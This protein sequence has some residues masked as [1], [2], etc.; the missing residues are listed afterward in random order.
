MQLPKLLIVYPNQFGYH[1]DTYMYCKYLQYKY[2]ITYVCFDQGFEK[3][4]IPGTEVVYVPYGLGKIKRLFLFFKTAIQKSNELNK[5]I[6][7][8]VQFK[9]SALL[10]LFLTS[11]LSILDYRTG[12]LSTNSL[13]RKFYNLWMRTDAVFFQRTSVISA[14]LRKMLLL[15]RST[16]V[17]PLGAEELSNQTK[18]FDK[19][20]L[21]Y[22]GAIH[23]RNIFQTVEGFALF[24]SQFPEYAN[25]I[26]YDI[27]G[28][29][30]D[31]D[32]S[33]LTHTIE[34]NHL[35]NSVFYHGRMPYTKLPP[36]FDKCNIGVSYIPITNYYQ[37]QPAT[38]TFEYA[39]SG[40]FTIATATLE[41]KKVICSENGTLCQDTPES[42]A[43]ALIYVFQ[44]KYRFNDQKIR[45]SLHEYHWKNIVETKLIPLL[46]K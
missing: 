36:F 44:N 18:N 12:D 7:L 9:F 37:H 43:D 25:D 39:L 38:K 41:N 20:Y 5:P 45:S 17:L 13:K 31:T 26:T 8:V 46:Q 23:H 16:Y 10:G 24:L 19:L 29:G 14:G 28:F 6:C 40:L 4:T 2:A 22:V 3:L 42:F 27:I 30:N 11:K 33:L 35:L 34:K 32:I 1:T 21:L 15:N